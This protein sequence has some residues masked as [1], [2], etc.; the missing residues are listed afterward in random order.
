MRGRVL[1]TMVGF[2]AVAF[3]LVSEQAAYGW[4][5][6]L[7]WVPDLVVGLACVGAGLMAWRHQR[8]VGVLLALTGF[9][10]F[11]GNL[12]AA[13]LFWHRGPLVHALVAYPGWRPRSR[14]GLVVVGLGYVAAVSAGWRDELAAVALSVLLVVAVGIEYA[15][16]AGPARRHARVELRVTVALAVVLVGGAAAR[17][18]VPAGNAVVPSLLVYEAAVAAVAVVLA[19]APHRAPAGDVTDLVVEL[20]VTRSETLRDALARVLGDPSLQVGYW[21]AE[22][23]GYLDAVGAPIAVPGAGDRRAATHVGRDGGRFAVV[24]HDRAVLDDPAVAEAVAEAT[25]LT[26]SHA[27]LRDEVRVLLVELEASRR[28]LLIAGDEARRGLERRLHDGPLRRLDG[29]RETLAAAAGPSPGGHLGRAVKQL[30][31]SYVWSIVTTTYPWLASS[32][33]TTVV[34]KRWSCAPCENTTTGSRPRNCRTGAPSWPAVSGASAASALYPRDVR[35][36]CVE[37]GEI[38]GAPAGTA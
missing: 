1:A 24:V 5:R 15:H 19:V 38:Q 33:T 20:G 13:A 36:A 34:S 27:A 21:S 12:A 8:G 2:V 17:L 32:C 31:A 26:S 3:G 28:R 4:G 23:R 7:R 22:V 37:V 14:V 10:W 9:A 18:A 35:S 25:R 11:A 29:L 16:R 6:P 30:A